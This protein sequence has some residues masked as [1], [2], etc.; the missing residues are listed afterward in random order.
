[1]W[2]VGLGKLQFV[3]TIN[4]RNLTNSNSQFYCLYSTVKRPALYLYNSSTRAELFLIG[5]DHVT[6]RSAELV[7]NL[8]NDVKP[9]VIA[10]ELCEERAKNLLADY[11]ERKKL[12][13]RDFLAIKG[14]LSQKF[15]TF[16]IQNMY[17]DLAC[18][19]L[20]P[21]EEIRVAIER[22]KAIGANISY[23]DKNIDDIIERA[24][25]GFVLVDVWRYWWK[26]KEIVSQYPNFF[27]ALQYTDIEH[28]A[29]A[30]LKPEVLQ[31]AVD[32][33][34]RFFPGLVEAILHE[35]NEHMVKNLREMK[36]S[37]VGVVGA[38]HVKG[39]QKL[40]QQR[41]AECR[42]ERSFQIM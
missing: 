20:K 32:I 4:T 40:W 25:Q 42:K 34:E 41:E 21:G 12:S 23:I 7:K 6:T 33:G 14:T 39:M 27:R 22:G 3:R 37:I 10:V 28:C 29:E 16:V 19:G 9:S 24:A 1:M 17:A 5:V 38:L 35:R 2:R 8:I 31:E 30:M 11:G 18:T 36:G 26:Q 13:L 15:I